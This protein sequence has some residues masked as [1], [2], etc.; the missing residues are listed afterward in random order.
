M[1]LL[2]KVDVGIRPQVS[3]VLAL[4]GI[5]YLSG[6][7]G[8]LVGPKSPFPVLSS[9]PV[10]LAFGLVFVLSLIIAPVL[11]VVLLVSYVRAGRPYRGWVYSAVIAAFSPWF[12]A[13]LFWLLLASFF[14]P[15]FEYKS[16]RPNT[17]LEPTA[18]ASSVSTNK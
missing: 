7:V 11:A 16:V 13:L 9:G 4:S 1:F 15:H 3:L 5:V 12:F 14:S 2:R 17:A 18:T 10:E 6:L 8:L